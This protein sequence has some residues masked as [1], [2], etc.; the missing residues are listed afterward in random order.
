MQQFRRQPKPEASPGG[1]V[2]EERRRGRGAQS[3]HTGRFE[4]ERRETFD[5]GW[6]G[7]AELDAFKTTVFDDPARTII[8]RNDSPDISFDR[9]INPYRGCEHGCIYCFARP[10]HCYLGHS[11]G[12]D[13][14]TKLYARTNAAQLLERELSNPRYQPACM[15]I[16]TNTDPYQPIER[17]RRIMRSVLEVLERTNHPVG[18]VTKSA[19]ITRD[20]DILSRMAERG[21]ARAALS[22]TTLDPKIARAMEPRA[23]TPRRR[24][25]AVKQLAAAGI[26]TTVMVA[27]IIPGLTDP[28]IESILEAAHEAG[29]TQAGYVMLR[30][31][32]EISTLFREWLA[33]E[34]PNRADRVMHLLQS[35]H[36]GRDYTA[37]FSIRQRGTGPYADQIAARFRL[38]VRRLGLNAERKQLRT[39]LFRHPVLKGQQM[40]LF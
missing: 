13:F 30:L 23:P 2:D 22:I 29:A 8:T 4:T 37:E 1:L 24:L 36:G 21:L 14:E 9:S 38:A 3:N 7:L 31:P 40:A 10:T 6:D 34:F 5:D 39:D 12:L 33:S 11:A 16:G 28:E 26:P 25:E 15:A 17:E 18:I 35:M 20:I 19:L 32:L 27:P